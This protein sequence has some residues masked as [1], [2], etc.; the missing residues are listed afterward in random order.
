MLQKFYY[1]LLLS[2]D[3]C[4]CIEQDIRFLDISYVKICVIE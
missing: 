4:K 3:Y 1:N 2:Q